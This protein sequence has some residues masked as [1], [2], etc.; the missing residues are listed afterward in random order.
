MVGDPP[1]QNG[2]VIQQEGNSY[3]LHVYI[4]NVQNRF[5]KTVNTVA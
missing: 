2:S 1:V 5:P 3:L 4:G